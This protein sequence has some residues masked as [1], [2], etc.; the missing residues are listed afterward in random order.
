MAF[1]GGQLIYAIASFLYG[2]LLMAVYE[3]IRFLRKRLKHK[4]WVCFLEDWMF[5]LVAAILVFQMIF[6]LN[7][8]IMR[9]FFILDFI[10]GM[11]LWRK[12]RHI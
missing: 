4:K 3:I 5:W 8:G 12:I 11:M 6:A 9:S 2:F 1:I 10:L 7:N